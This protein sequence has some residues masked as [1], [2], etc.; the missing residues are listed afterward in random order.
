M[1]VYNVLTNAALFMAVLMAVMT[2]CTYDV[3]EPQWYADYQAPPTPTI[4]QV[5]P[6]DVAGPG[7]STITITGTNFAVDPDTNLVYFGNVRAEIV[8]ASATAIT[9]LRPNLVTDSAYIKVVS[10]KALVVAKLAQPYKIDQ[11]HQRWGSFLVATEALSGAAIDDNENLYVTN[12]SSKR[13]YKVDPTNNQILLGE[14]TRIP[15]DAKIGPDGNLVL[16]CTNRVIEAMDVTTGAVSEWGRLP[17]GKNAKFGDFDANGYLYTGGAKS[18]LFTIGPDKNPV[19]ST[20]YAKDDINAVRVY[21]GYLYLLIKPGGTGTVQ[22]IVRHSIGA[23]G[24]LGPKEVMLEWNEATVG[25]LVTRTIRGITFSSTG[26]MY[27]V[28]D[29]VDPLLMVDL[30]A[31]TVQI[32]YKGILPGYCKYFCGSSRQYIYMIVGDTTLGVEWTVYR[33]DVGVAGAP[34]L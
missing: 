19:A 18:D 25:T 1:K 2:G 15:A 5:T 34:Y 20:L 6:A 30:T 21:N 11:V 8:A 9:V 27:A 12:Q 3:A 10:P 29:S 4:T 28:T 13:I 24:A 7:V 31:K 17:T 22:T 32:M 16:M 23:A 33:V 14:A 26:I